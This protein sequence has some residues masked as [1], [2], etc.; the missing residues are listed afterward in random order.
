MYNLNKNI[1][2][3]NNFKL[4]SPPR[5]ISF[6]FA[7]RKDL[8]VVSARPNQHS[9]KPQQARLRLLA[10][11]DLHARLLDYDYDRDRPAPGSGLVCLAGHIAAA[12][13]EVPGTLLF[14]N[15]DTYQ[16]TALGEYLV[17]EGGPHPIAEALAAL[18]LD[19]AV[20]G[21]HDFNF[22]TATL[23]G[24]AETARFPFVLTNLVSRRGAAPAE[25]TPLLP[26]TLLLERHV[27]DA[28]GVR[29]PIRIGVLGFVPPQTMGWD[30][31]LRDQNIECR[32]I[33]EAA[34]G[35]LP[36]L[37]RAGADIVVALCHSGL[38]P[39]APAPGLEDAARLIARLPGI[40]AV[41]SGHRHDVTSEAASAPAAPIVAPGCNGS[42]LGQIDLVLGRTA[43]D[44]PWQVQGSDVSLLPAARIPGPAAAPLA[45]IAAP[46]H[47]RLR[48]TLSET[49]GWTDAPLH[50][51][52]AGV[53]PGMA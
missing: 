19:A 14:D 17:Q 39:M 24:L 2:T 9:E 16:G 6:V 8:G 38:G 21:N 13:A 10:I 44:G 52:F 46:S 53:L 50:S 7:T 26:P 49:I 41:I 51:F 33:V 48:A 18:Q 22:G 32:D 40:D 36:G 27:V 30:H 23:L 29:H 5:R 42:H 15:G 43:P 34:C 35:W 1:L 12:R 11:T 45:R 3:N 31:D 25:D 28:D 4:Y 37:K 47:A 20:P